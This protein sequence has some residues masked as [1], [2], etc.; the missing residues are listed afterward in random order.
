MHKSNYGDI[1]LSFAAF[2]QIAV[3]MFQELLTSSNI[4]THESS[5]V[6]CIIV[7]AIPMI[8]AVN[9]II[10]RRLKLF[11]ITYMIS[12]LIILLTLLIYPENSK[13]IIPGTFNILFVNIPSLLCLASIRSNDILKRILLYLSFLILTLGMIYLSL[14]WIGKIK[15]LNYSMTFSYYLLLPSLVFVSQKKIIFTFLFLSV[16]FIM[17][18][19]GSRGAL[20]TSLIYAFLLLFIDR[21]TSKNI[22]FTSLI[23]VL[24]IISGSFLSFFLKLSDNMAVSSRTMDLLLSGDITEDT[25]RLGIFSIIWNS[26]LT[27]PFVGYGIFGD[28]VI[29]DGIYCHNFL[30]EILCNFGILFGATFILLLLF[31]IIKSFTSSDSANKKLLLMLLCYTF[32]PLMVSLSYLE[33]PQFGIFVGF[34][35]SLS[36]NNSDN[37]FKKIS[38]EQNY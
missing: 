6:A 2:F 35:L 27:K 1:I 25:G 19:L 17:L 29:L 34:L 10:A 30:L 33:F 11:L 14:L 37:L 23:L 5:R 36:R 26:I 18:M 22:I 31:V 7:S 3:L 20:V 38:L 4:V 32:V 12:I 16:C 24:V 15:F 28:R 8:I 13:Y 9:Y 21:E